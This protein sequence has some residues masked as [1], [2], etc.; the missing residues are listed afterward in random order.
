MKMLGLFAAI[1][2]ALFSTLF[3]PVGMAKGVPDNDYQKPVVYA[4]GEELV[5]SL[6][7]GIF[8]GGEG[9]L[10]VKDTVLFGNKVHHIVATG[11]TV[12]LADALFRVRDRYESFV[13]PQ[14]DLPVKSIR[15][16]REGRYRY[17][18][19]V[20]FEHQEDSAKVFSQKSGKHWVPANIQD[21]VSAFYFARKYK[22]NDQ[23]RQGEVMEILTYF[24]DELYPLR[25]RYRGTEVIQTAFGKMECYLFSPVTEVGRAFKT[26]DDMQVW[27]TRD[28]NRLPVRIRFNLKVGSFICNLEQFRGLKNPFSSVVTP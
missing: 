21:I 4:P 9:R 2:I 22:F 18:N 1:L 8:R 3:S 20:V 17:Y 11:N 24:S 15:N 27:I 19:E 16:I 13:N 28:D 6:N 12:G 10:L 25:I 5:Y 14:T 23:M 7:Y 26:E